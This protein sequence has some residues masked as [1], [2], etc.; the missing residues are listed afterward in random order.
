MKLS[1]LNK[2]MQKLPP[3]LDMKDP[4]QR[5]QFLR[6]QGVD[7]STLYQELEMES[8]FVDCHQ[9]VSYSNTQV[10]LHSH[11]FYEFL[12]ACNTCGAEYLVGTERYRLKKGDIVLVP[13]GLSHRP[14]LPEKMTE[15]YKRIVL[16]ISADFMK[17][18]LRSFPEAA[19]FEQAYSILLRT[20]GT[21]WESLGDL[22]YSALQAAQA[23]GAEWQMLLAG[24]TI[25]LLAQLHRSFLNSS[26]Q[27]M[28]AE[29]P[30]LL[31]SL[32]T[33]IEENLS[34]T[35]TLTEAA[36]HFY[37]SEST[38]SQTFRKKLGVSF[39]QYVT[40]R[41][42]IA[43]KTL[44]EQGIMLEDVAAR[45]GFGDYSG[46]YRSFKKEYGVSPRQYRKVQEAT[47][48]DLPY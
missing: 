34:Q 1:N 25:T 32:L 15:P 14:L 31:D 43:A 4:E 36:R 45:T 11:N 9:D 20:A 21:R 33:Y 3:E 22:F 12:Y 26:A 44:I 8:P 10:N 19:E 18:L 13:P 47:H 41:R 24:T 6:Q 23:G 46:F 39:Y 40:Q 16:W 27:P 2:L 30:E 5:N 7:P 48:R 42:L 17:G 37:V 29:K 35:L 28:R 38:I